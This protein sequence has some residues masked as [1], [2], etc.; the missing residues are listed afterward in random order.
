M[1][2]RRQ[3]TEGYA[4]SEALRSAIG[5]MSARDVVLLRP[6]PEDDPPWYFRIEKRND[7]ITLYQIYPI[8]EWNADE[9]L[10]DVLARLAVVGIEDVA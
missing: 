3:R 2:T 9:P 8:L 6:L 1:S 10:H 7:H 5:T 4:F